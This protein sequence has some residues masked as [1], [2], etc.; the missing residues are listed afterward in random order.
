MYRIRTRVL[1]PAA[2]DRATWWPDAV[3][4]LTDDGRIGAI[5][6]AADHDGPVDLHAPHGVLTPGF[7]DGHVHFPQ[8]RIIGAASGPLLQWLDTST[9]P[10]ESRFADPATAEAVATMFCDA[11]AGAG[12]TLAMVY[13]SGHAPASHTLL[14]A[15]DRRGLRGIVGPVWMDSGAP[16]AL[17]RSTEHTVEAVR[18]LVETWHGHDDGRLSVAV[19]PR[20]ALSCTAPMMAAAGELA[21]AHDLAVT[22]HL[23]ETVSECAAVRERFGA[24]YLDVYDDAG[25]L[26]PRTVFAHCIHLSDRD[27]DRLA[28]AGAIVAHCPDSNDFLGSGGMPL[29]QVTAR[30]LPLVLGTDVAAG[31]SFRVPRIASSAFDNALRQ[32]LRTDPATWLWHATRGGAL[33]L[34]VDTVGQVRPGLEADLVLHDLPPWVDDPDEALGWLLF[35]HDAPRPRAVWVRGRQVFDR[36]DWAAAGA[37]FPWGTP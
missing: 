3:V 1:S 25:L 31:R 19:V 8:T 5:V 22:T 21:R 30:D 32:G 15:M 14:S 34:G 18:G 27:W 11:L 2:P 24:D 20:F 10:E 26:D 28:A 36:S 17:L 13:G 12:T 23:A 29:A 33:A 4:S 7:V 9:F 37:G 35:H 6:D 16:D